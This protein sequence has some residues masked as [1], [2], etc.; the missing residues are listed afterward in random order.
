M[1]KK[2]F[3]NNKYEICDLLFK[4]DSKVITYLCQEKESIGFESQ[5]IKNLFL[6]LCFGSDY[7]VNSLIEEPRLN[8]LTHREKSDIYLIIAE[9]ETELRQINIYKYKNIK[10]IVCENI[11]VSEID[12][13]NRRVCKEKIAP[14]FFVYFFSGDFCHIVSLFDDNVEIL[15]DGKNY[16]GKRSAI[17]I[18]KSLRL[19]MPMRESNDI[20][21]NKVVDNYIFQFGSQMLEIQTNDDRIDKIILREERR[22]S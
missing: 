4:E 11:F 18:L 13:E 12:L 19:S 20:N 15:Q 2:S 8:I 7:S 16:Y 3:T 17:M 10:D 9:L 21:I 5:G 14:Y 22:P 6:D 1:I